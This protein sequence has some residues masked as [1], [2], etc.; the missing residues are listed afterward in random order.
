MALSAWPLLARLSAIVVALAAVTVPAPALADPV[1][2]TVD[3][4]ACVQ[5]LVWRDAREGDTVC[6]TPAFRARTLSENAAPAVN[7]DPNG[8]FGPESCVEGFVW[9]EAFDGDKICVTIEVRAENQEA[10]AAAESNYLRS[11]LDV[12]FEITGSGSVYTINTDPDVGSAPENTAVPWKRTA[13]IGPDVTLLQV[14]AIT[15][16][17][18]QGCRITVDDVVVID[19]PPGTSAH[20]VYYRE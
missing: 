17:G 12:V 20:C 18:D 19:Q 8:A 6:V 15:K 2:P 16:S 9:R 14:I 1:E 5:G 13:T 7:A 4:D 10:N 11:Q 3:P